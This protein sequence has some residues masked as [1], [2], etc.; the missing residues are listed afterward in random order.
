MVAHPNTHRIRIEKL[1]SINIHVLL[2]CVLFSLSLHPYY[3]IATNAKARLPIQW[4][5]TDT[6]LLIKQKYAKHFF[7]VVVASFY[8]LIQEHRFDICSFCLL[9]KWWIVCWRGCGGRWTLDIDLLAFIPSWTG[10]IPLYIFQFAY[11]MCAGCNWMRIVQPSDCS[12]S[13]MIRS[14]VKL[15]I[16]LRLL[17]L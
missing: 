15:S 5:A 4:I 6:S 10:N 8:I 11:L 16:F 17:T 13:D 1:F 2:Q 14:A 3:P 9:E 12:V 7:V